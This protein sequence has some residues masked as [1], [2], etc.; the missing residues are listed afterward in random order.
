MTLETFLIEI[1]KK[2]GK[3]FPKLLNVDLRFRADINPGD[4]PTISD[5]TL[6]K[7]T[8]KELTL[9]ISLSGS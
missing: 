9:T 2:T 1:A 3:K 8:N 4:K 5:I 7:G 6:E